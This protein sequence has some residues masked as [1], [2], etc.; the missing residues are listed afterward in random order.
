MLGIGDDPH[1]P[2][3]IRGESKWPHNSSPAKQ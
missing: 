3:Y 2:I 1:Y